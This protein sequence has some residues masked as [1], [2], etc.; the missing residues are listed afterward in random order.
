MA[1]SGVAYAVAA[2]L[3]ATPVVT[4]GK[5]THKNIIVG[6]GCRRGIGPDEVKRAVRRAL[7]ENDISMEDIRVA[8]TVDLKK[9]EKGLIK[10][11]SGLDLPLVFIPKESIMNFKAPS[12]SEV[13]RR[14][15]GLDGVCEPAALLAGRRTRLIS[16]K[17]ASGGVAIAIAKEG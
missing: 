8:A 4:T 1:I 12:P 9:D 16:G 3:G 17:R 5:E 7:R 2:S 13:V 6:I 15:I 14:N 11:C 10:A